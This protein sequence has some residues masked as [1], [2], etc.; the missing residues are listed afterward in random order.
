[1]RQDAS[2]GYPTD[3]LIARIKGRATTLVT[4]WRPLLEQRRAPEASDERIW[5]ALL[6]ELEW[7][8]AQMNRD[9]RDAFAPLFALFEIKTIV[10]CLRNRALGRTSEIARLVVR[11]LLA[12]D[13]KQTLLQGPDVRSTIAALGFREESNLLTFENA[14]MRAYLQDVA[15]GKLEPALKAFFTLFI[16]MRNVMLL[17]KRLRWNLGERSPFIAGGSL[18][19]SVLENIRDDASFDDLLKR[20]TGLDALSVATSEGA[21]ETILLRFITN[22]LVKSRHAAD[23]VAL[24]VVYIW[25]LY[26]QARNLSVLHHGIDLEPRT[27]ERELI[28]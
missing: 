14:L 17:Y 3:Y 18:A 13:V 4:N 27:L 10:L 2:D 23:D 22:Q 6:R 24:I 28:L 19:T 1:M 20:F 15:A 9:L 21:L 26:V 11:S 25:R 7:L 12:E 8:H 5:E 16:D